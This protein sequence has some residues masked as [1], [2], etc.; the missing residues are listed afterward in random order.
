M[1][2]TAM[3]RLPDNLYSL[4]ELRMERISDP[5]LKSRTAGIVSL[6]PAGSARRGSDQRSAS[7]PA[8]MTTP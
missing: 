2:Y 3:P 6:V 8:G 7:K 1:K 5:H 4:P